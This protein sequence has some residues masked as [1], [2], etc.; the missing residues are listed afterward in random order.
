MLRGRQVEL[1]SDDTP[2]LDSLL[3]LVTPELR[4][5]IMELLRYM[6]TIEKA[7]QQYIEFEHGSVNQARSATHNRINNKEAP[8]TQ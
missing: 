2:K 5:R 7:K 6:R 8:E 4:E 3:L 1:E